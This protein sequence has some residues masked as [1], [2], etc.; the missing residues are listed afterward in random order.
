MEL[1]HGTSVS[2]RLKEE[3]CTSLRAVLHSQR[4]DTRKVLH[5]LSKLCGGNLVLQ[6]A[7]EQR[8][9]L[10]WVLHWCSGQVGGNILKGR[11]NKRHI[12]Q[13]QK[14]RAACKLAQRRVRLGLVMMMMVA[15]AAVAA[16]ERR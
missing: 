2:T 16:A 13:S 8:G 5:D 6:L 4:P 7:N 12:L 11:V 1:H 3:H 15:A 14:L 10:V 9:K